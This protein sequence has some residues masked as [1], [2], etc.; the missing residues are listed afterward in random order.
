M[1][2]LK[3]FEKLVLFFWLL[4]IVSSGGAEVSAQ[5]RQRIYRDPAARFTLNL[6]TEFS[7]NNKSKTLLR[8]LVEEPRFAS[9]QLEIS[10][11]GSLGFEEIKLSLLSERVFFTPVMK[12]HSDD[13]RKNI[14]IARSIGIRV[15]D[16]RLQVGDFVPDGQ[17]SR[18]IT[19]FFSSEQFPYGYIS[20][21]NFIGFNA[22]SP[23]AYF[24]TWVPND[25]FTLMFTISEC[26]EHPGVA[27][28][29]LG[30]TE[31]MRLASYSELM[32]LWQKVLLSIKFN[33]PG[34]K[35][36]KKKEEEKGHAK[37][38]ERLNCGDPSP[39]VS[40]YFS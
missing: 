2:K 26:S 35:K 15:V 17:D 27:F 13:H 14:S 40:G 30:E 39:I 25:G 9:R 18:E 20:S 22:V 37:I 10:R 21:S 7:E 1:P 34:E 19:K 24:H 38:G 29:D 11:R 36:G 3:R 28:K 31:S 8:A 4:L 33:P 23:C 32:K 5:E 16:R 6:P 12:V